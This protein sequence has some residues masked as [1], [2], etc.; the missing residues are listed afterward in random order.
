MG[1]IKESFSAVP[2]GGKIYDSEKYPL[3]FRTINF[4]G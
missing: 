1:M 3:F 2:V 4:S